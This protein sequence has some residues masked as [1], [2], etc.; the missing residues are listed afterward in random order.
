MDQEEMQ[1]RAED[2]PT[3][4][5]LREKLDAYESLAKSRGWAHLVEDLNEAKQ[6]VTNDA[7]GSAVSENEAVN[8]AYLKGFYQGISRCLDLPT[9]MVEDYLKP[10]VEELKSEQESE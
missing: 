7:L 4:E 8:S 2:T 6:Q 9:T 10:L 5:S 3:L 1:Q